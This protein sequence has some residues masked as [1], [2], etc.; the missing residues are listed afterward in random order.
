[1]N[2][3]SIRKKCAEIVGWTWQE[4]TVTH[5]GG[6]WECRTGKNY[7]RGDWGSKEL[8]IDLPDYPE[9]VDAALELVAWM[10]KPENGWWFVEINSD[11]SMAEH[12]QTW[13]VALMRMGEKQVY[14]NSNSFALAICLAFLKANNIDPETL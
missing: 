12:D 1:M 9:S 6:Y 8:G 2:T 3:E 13:E 10:A 4:N 7:E 11:L 14:G 5:I